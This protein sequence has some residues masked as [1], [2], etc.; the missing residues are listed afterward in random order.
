MTSAHRIFGSAQV[1]LPSA[2]KD[3]GSGSVTV[4]VP[5]DFGAQIELDSGSG[6]VDVDVP[7]QIREA[8]RDYLRGTIGDGEGRAEIDTGSGGIDIRSN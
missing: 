8:K 4:S 6:G 2:R 3:T 7:V 5:D 1:T